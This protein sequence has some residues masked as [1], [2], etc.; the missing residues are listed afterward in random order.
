MPNDMDHNQL[1]NQS[2]QQ[3]FTHCFDRVS[4]DLV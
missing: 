4:F 1:W 3:I 2:S